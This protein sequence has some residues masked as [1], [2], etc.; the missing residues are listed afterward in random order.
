MDTRERKDHRFP[1]DEIL[2]AWGFV[3]RLR[4]NPPEEP[5]WGLMTTEGEMRF[6]QTEALLLVKEEE[7]SR[8]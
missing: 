1:A 5:T 8:A 2:R 3:L 4:P 7:E 6:S